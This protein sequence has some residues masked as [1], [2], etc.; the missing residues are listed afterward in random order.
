MTGLDDSLLQWDDWI[1][2][3][4]WLTNQELLIGAFLSSPS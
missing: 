2:L 1:G 3:D 4:V